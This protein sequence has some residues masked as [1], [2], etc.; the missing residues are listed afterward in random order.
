MRHIVRYRKI[1]V[2]NNYMSVESAVLEG[3]VSHETFQPLIVFTASVTIRSARTRLIGN[4]AKEPI[5]AR[6]GCTTAQA[7]AA[8]SVFVLIIEI[9]DAVAST[10]S[11]AREI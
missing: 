10:I 1:L 9:R 2:S 7:L 5:V 8:E 6:I 3:Y 4:L 11:I